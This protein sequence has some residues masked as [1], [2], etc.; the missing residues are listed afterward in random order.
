MN[1]S[2]TKLFVT[3]KSADELKHEYDR[4][5]GKPTLLRNL[6]FDQAEMADLPEVL[7]GDIRRLKQVL[8]NLVKN[9]KKFTPN[10][11]INIYAAYDYR[12]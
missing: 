10:G 1:R 11:K 8:I 6:S 3:I 9:A 5:K 2:G 7:I 4:L 12:K